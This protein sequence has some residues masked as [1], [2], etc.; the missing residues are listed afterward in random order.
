MPAASEAGPTPPTVPFLSVCCLV[1]KEGP[2]C[3]DQTRSSENF[4]SSV[5]W[6]LKLVPSSNEVRV[7]SVQLKTDFKNITWHTVYNVVFSR[8]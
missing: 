1:G 5:D 3:K 7:P 4:L 2:W 6:Q 8:P